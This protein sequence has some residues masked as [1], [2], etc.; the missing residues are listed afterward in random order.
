M[1]SGLVRLADSP[2]DSSAVIGL[3]R[4]PRWNTIYFAKLNFKLFTGRGRRT[5][6]ENKYMPP[7]PSI[8]PS[9]SHE[10]L[11]NFLGYL[12]VLRMRVWKDSQFASFEHRCNY[13]F[14]AGLQQNGAFHLL[15]RNTHRKT[16]KSAYQLVLGEL[17]CLKFKDI[18]NSIW[19]LCGCSACDLL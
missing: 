2:L 6:S 17:H 9:C 10:S 19:Y 4:T 11:S 8:Y 18:E 7:F 3:P 13:S 12:C 14:T 16:N 15:E 1:A 5:Y